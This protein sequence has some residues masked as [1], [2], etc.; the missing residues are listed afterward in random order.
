MKRI[1]VE[2]LG[3]LLRVNCP[4]DTGALRAS[5]SGVQGNEEEWIITIGNEDASINGTPT[6]NYA[7]ALNFRETINNRQNRHY[8]WV[9]DTVKEWIE[10]NKLLLSLETDDDGE[11]A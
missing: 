2:K 10:K 6:I 11:D 5:I 3:Q 7:A 9:N 4:I 1:Y 8:H